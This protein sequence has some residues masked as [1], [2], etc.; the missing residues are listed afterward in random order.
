ML[1]SYL[2]R[3]D[4]FHLLQMY[5][6]LHEGWGILYRGTVWRVDHA[7][8]S[9]IMSHPIHNRRCYNN[10]FIS[11]ISTPLVITTAHN[12]NDIPSLTIDAVRSLR[13]Q[14]MHPNDDSIIQ[15][16]PQHTNTDDVTNPPALGAERV[17][18]FYYPKT[19]ELFPH[20][21][22]LILAMPIKQ[23]STFEIFIS[24][25]QVLCYSTPILLYHNSFRPPLHS[26]CT[27]IN[28]VTN[29]INFFL[30]G[31]TKRYPSATAHF[32]SLGYDQQK[33][34]GGCLGHMG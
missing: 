7:V 4:D 16:V 12:F 27:T 14:C 17:N 20:I 24:N 25:V 19:L 11:S 29:F 8:K 34:P 28:F 15:T 32:H 6:T 3:T 33:Q 10:E 9:Y 18:I 31:T 22:R 23:I 1:F 5:P 21:D 13:I 26:T 2:P 30:S